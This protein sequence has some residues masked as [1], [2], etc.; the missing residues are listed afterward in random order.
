MNETTMTMTNELTVGDVIQL[1]QD[2][3][4][5]FMNEI[6][7]TE[8]VFRCS[9]EFGAVMCNTGMGLLIRSKGYDIRFGGYKYFYDM[10][11]T[12][13]NVLINFNEKL[14]IDRV[15]E[16][17]VT[18]KSLDNQEKEFWVTKEEYHKLNFKKIDKID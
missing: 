18:I 7:E 4:D 10:F 5:T 15:G 3:L 12:S 9:G 2:K 8:N 16:V 6:V 13:K 11:I 14:I 1:D 17:T